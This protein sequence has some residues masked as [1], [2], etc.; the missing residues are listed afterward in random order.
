MSIAIISLIG[1][2]YGE[3]VGSHT[4][5]DAYAAIGAPERPA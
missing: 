5:G 1:K 2:T 4:K 3:L